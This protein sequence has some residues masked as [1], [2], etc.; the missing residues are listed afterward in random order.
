[1]VSVNLDELKHNIRVP[2]PAQQ[3]G[4]EEWVLW[5]LRKEATQNK[6]PKQNKTQR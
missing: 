4:A 6:T 3:D 1:M 5:N 2:R